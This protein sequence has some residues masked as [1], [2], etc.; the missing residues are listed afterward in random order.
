M[1]DERSYRPLLLAAVLLHA[2]Q[3]RQDFGWWAVVKQ[4]PVSVF[5]PGQADSLKGI[6]YLTSLTSS[7]DRRKRDGCPPR[8]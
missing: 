8:K 6:G 1:L 2:F 5:G 7:R 3:P 4:P